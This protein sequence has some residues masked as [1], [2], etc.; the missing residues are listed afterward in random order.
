[1]IVPNKQNL[2]LLKKKSKTIKSGMKLLKEKRTGLVALFVRLAKEGKALESKVS[3][4]QDNVLEAYTE[5]MSFISIS[6]LV[7]NLPSQAKLDLKVEKKRISGV[8]L[9]NFTID[10]LAPVRVEL[11]QTLTNSLSQFADLFP[12]LLMLIQL[13]MNVEKISIEIEKTNRLIN[14]LE[15]KTEEIMQQTKY[16]KRVLSEKENFEKATLIKIFG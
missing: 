6:G 5:A 4:L 10:I 2:L 13:K 7:D 14:N 12:D 16:I 15:K 1:M 8:Y 3:L 11:K 9:E